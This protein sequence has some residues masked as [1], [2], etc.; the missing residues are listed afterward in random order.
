M[1]TGRWVAKLPIKHHLTGGGDL[2]TGGQ[3][4]VIAAGIAGS[5]DVWLKRPRIK[6]YVDEQEM[7]VADLEW[8]KDQLDDLARSAK[9]TPN[10]LDGVLEEIYDWADREAVWVQ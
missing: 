6:R 5:I 3:I 7:D 8:A 10:D 4:S 2:T 1:A 9:G